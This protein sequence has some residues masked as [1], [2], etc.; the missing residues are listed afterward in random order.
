VNRF[1][2]LKKLAWISLAVVPLLDSCF[3]FDDDTEEQSSYIALGFVSDTTAILFSYNWKTTK[4][5]QC[6]PGNAGSCAS[7]RKDYG[8]ELKL[9]DVRFQ[10]VYWSARIDHNMSNNQ[11]LVGRQWN[12][13]TML[14]ELSGKGYWLWAVGDKKPQKI[15]FNWNVEPE[16]YET[17]MLLYRFRFRPWK[18]DSV[19]IYS[20]DRQAIIDSKTMT[21][22][23]WSPTGENTWTT[24]CDDF[25]WGKN[26]GG[27]L[28]NKPDGFTLLSD[29]GDTLGNFTYAYECVTYYDRKCNINSY[30]YHNFIRAWL[31]EC[32]MSVCDAHPVNAKINENYYTSI[33]YDG[34]WNINEEP[35]FWMI[36]LKRFVDSLGNIMEY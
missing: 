25:Q 28:I 27:C 34:K 11:I 22:N 10:K 1:V 18:N 35:S 9:V 36:G 6:G 26:S 2:F 15:N 17:D 33:R 31:G 8:W 5:S 14:I 3:F 30:F 13:S 7:G 21:V 24:A 20:G 12:D 16:N 23:S 19:L 29:K 32:M 4:G